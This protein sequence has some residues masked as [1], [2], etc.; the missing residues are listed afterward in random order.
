MMLFVGRALFF[1][2]RIKITLDP[3]VL[4][5]RRLNWSIRWSEIKDVRLWIKYSPNKNRD[6]E[7]AIMYIQFEKPGTG[8]HEAAIQA[9][10]LDRTPEEICSLI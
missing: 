4:T 6:V 3:K 2:S 1:D 9:T 5:D 7:G 10:M 8:L